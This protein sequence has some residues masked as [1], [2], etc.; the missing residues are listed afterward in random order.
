MK[1]KDRKPN[2]KMVGQRARL[3]VAEQKLINR[4]KS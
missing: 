3:S 1:K 2:L 4:L